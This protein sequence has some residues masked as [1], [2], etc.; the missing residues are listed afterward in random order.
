MRAEREAGNLP[1]QNNLAVHRKGKTW[2]SPSAN[3]TPEQGGD[4]PPC[5]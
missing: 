5:K 3:L 1:L 4:F 2:C